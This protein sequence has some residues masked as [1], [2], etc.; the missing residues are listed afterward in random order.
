MRG[1]R[2]TEVTS[3]E[4]GEMIVYGLA[5][6]TYYLVET[7]APDGYV[8]KKEA[9]EIKID[10]LSHTVEGVATVD[11]VRNG[12]LPNTGGIGTTVF[13]VSGIVLVLVAILLLVWKKY[14]A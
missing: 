9:T 14:K 6:G 4:N 13:T 2:V 8:L 12:L 1:E 3:N 11:N 7:K 5:Y 10:E